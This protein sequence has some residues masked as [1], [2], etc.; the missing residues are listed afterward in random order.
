M[1]LWL[2]NLAAYSVQLAALVTAAVAVTWLLRFRHPR[3]ALRFW[4]I[5]PR[6]RPAAAGDSAV[7]AATS[8]DAHRLDR[9]RSTATATTAPAGAGPA[10][11]S[12][13]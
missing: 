7:A 3:P 12:P 6:R 13:P 4:Q 9:S 5:A 8:S 11:R 2:S 1:T 10:S